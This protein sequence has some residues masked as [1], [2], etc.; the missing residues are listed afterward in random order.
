V[1]PD[2]ILTVSTPVIRWSCVK[3]LEGINSVRSTSGPSLLIPLA[4]LSYVSE[5]RGNGAWAGS[6]ALQVAA[7]ASWKGKQAGQRKHDVA[8][9]A[10]AEGVRPFGRS[11][12]ATTRRDWMMW[13]SQRKMVGSEATEAG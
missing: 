10:G 12:A 7:A 3:T 5:K 2:A 1:K 13:F 6:A 4:G 11:E 8:L 9:L